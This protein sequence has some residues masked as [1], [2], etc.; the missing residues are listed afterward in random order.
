[1]LNCY[2]FLLKKRAFL[3]I[4]DS[5]LLKIA[6]FSRFFTTFFLP[7]LPKLC[8]L[9][10]QPPFSIRCPKDIVKNRKSKMS[11]FVARKAYIVLI[12]HLLRNNKQTIR[13][14]IAPLGVSVFGW[15]KYLKRRQKS[16]GKSIK[17][18]AP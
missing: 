15:I 7:I 1:M 18:A 5:F 12:P 14:S 9:T 2:P 3:R 10:C 13:G 4:F 16:K 8:N 6:H 17:S 11:R